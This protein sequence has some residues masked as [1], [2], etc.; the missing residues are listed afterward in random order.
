MQVNSIQQ[1]QP[2]FNGY[3]K[4]NVRKLVTNTIKGLI[5]EKIQ[6][7]DNLQRKVNTE[8]LLSLKEIGK[9]I[10]EDF[11]AFISQTHKDTFLDF[12]ESGYFSVGNTNAKQR[13][14]FSQPVFA[15]DRGEVNYSNIDIRPPSKPISLNELKRFAYELP[16]FVNPRKVDE[17]IAILSKDNL[18]DKFKL[19]KSSGIIKKYFA[20]KNA[21]KLDKY[22]SDLNMELNAKLDLENKLTHIEDV[23]KSRDYYKKYNKQAQKD[24][25]KGL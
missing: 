9:N 16:E 12:S 3:I 10:L 22:A 17:H 6:T 24:M 8:D 18:L 4:P 25:L 23:R 1:S 5:K 11:D 14:Y 2:N 13:L 19:G 7:A 20:R 21:D 15:K